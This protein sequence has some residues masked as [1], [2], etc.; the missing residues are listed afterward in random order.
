MTDIFSDEQAPEVKFDDLVGEGKKYRDPDALAKK[1]VHADQHISNLES[2]LAELRQE[3]ATRTTIE[4]MMDKLNQRQ[5]TREPLDTTQPEP[6]K[7]QVDLT[8]EVQRLLAAEKEKDRRE[9]NISKTRAGLRERFGADYNNRLTQIADE[10]SV[11]KDFLTQMAASSPEGFMKLVDSV[12]KPDDNRPVTPPKGSIDPFKIASPGTKN[13][14]Y[15]DKI[16]KEDP[17][18]YFSRRVQNEM[19]AEAVKQGASFYQ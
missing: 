1:T 15:Y 12:A 5:P 14:A 18:L 3:L 17:N 4:D 11:S 6:G 13:K 16:R 8:S 7:D 2:E 9:A 10:L 19:H